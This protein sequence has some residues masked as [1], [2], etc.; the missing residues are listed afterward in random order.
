MLRETGRVRTKSDLVVMPSE[1][2][3]FAFFCS[4]RDHKPQNSGCGYTEQSFHTAWVTLRHAEQSAARQV[5]PRSA[6]I[7]TL[8]PL[9][10][11]ELET[12]RNA[13]FDSRYPCGTG[14]SA[15]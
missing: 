1:G 11:F 7:T 3:V 2:R 12:N 5:T 8:C 9:G 13:C 10:N 6:D 15:S 14:V 4:E